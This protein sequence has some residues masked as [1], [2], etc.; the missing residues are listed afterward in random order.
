MATKEKWTSLFEQVVGRKPSPAEFMAGKTSDFD[1]KQIRQIAGLDAVSGQSLTDSSV[2]ETH[3]LEQESHAITDGFIGAEFSPVEETAIHQEIPT[4]ETP[5]YETPTY[6]QVDQVQPVYQEQPA[7]AYKQELVYTTPP[8]K[9][10]LSQG[11]KLKRLFMGV[12]VLAALG[13]VAGYYYLDQQTGPEVAVETFTK[14]FESNDYD[15]MAKLLST[16]ETKWTK[17]ETKGFLDYLESNSIN[18]KSE[19]EKLVN[20]GGETVFN[21]DRGNKLLGLKEVGKRFGLF[22]DYQVAT[23]P[24]DLVVTGN[25]DKLSVD[26]QT[27]EKNKDVNL[28]QIK[29]APKQMAVTAKTDLGDLKTNVSLDLDEIEN[30]QIKMALVSV[31]KQLSATLPDGLTDVEKVKLVV[32]G[33]EVADSL[34]KEVALLDNQEIK[35]HA[36]FTY[37]GNEYTS[38]KAKWNTGREKDVPIELTLSAETQKRISE[39]KKAKEAKDEAARQ[40]AEAEKEK[41]RQLLATKDKAYNFLTNYRKAV[42]DS[43]RNRTNTYSSYYDPNSAVYQAMVNYTVNG[44]A[45]DKKVD[46]LSP[47][48]FSVTDIVQKDNNTYEVTMHNTFTEYYFSGKSDYVEKYQT[49]FIRTD[50]DSFKIYDIQERIVQ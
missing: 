21:D 4:A 11:Q 38:E 12:G 19:L 13:L 9:K 7:P 14:A 37:E 41:E 39:A 43:I 44:G 40:A 36:I 42:Y 32:N 31:P 2:A 33:K 3:G 22:S 26:G 49:F 27:I 18:L 20:S 16:K 25:L 48:D 1:L 29:F 8:V 24:V 30:N 17:E 15:Q 47:G 34:T 23:Y 5:V 46:Y 45:N 10:I 6:E 35:V 28:G 50:G